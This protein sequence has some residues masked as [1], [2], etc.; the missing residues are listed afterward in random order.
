MS[1]RAPK[2]FANFTVVKHL[3]RGSY[4]DTYLVTS[5][6]ERFALK[7]LRP[8][9]AEGG[10]LRYQNEV[11]ALKQLNNRSI[12]KLISHGELQGYPYIVMSFARGRVFAQC[13][14]G[15]A[16]RGAPSASSRQSSSRRAS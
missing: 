5:G 11:W 10:A 4:G 7:W 3:G 9:P 6:R 16:K 8:D 12:P 2:S 1:R 15:K 13:S 14:N